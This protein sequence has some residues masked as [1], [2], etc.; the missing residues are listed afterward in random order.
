LQGIESLTSFVSR[1][2]AWLGYLTVSFSRALAGKPVLSI[3]LL[4]SGRPQGST[5][6]LALSAPGA[7]GD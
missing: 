2:H 4:I 6:I 1:R 3:V 5:I 7:G